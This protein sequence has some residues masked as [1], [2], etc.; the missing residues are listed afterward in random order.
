MDE[1][2]YL[3]S[4]KIYFLTNWFRL[5]GEEGNSDLVAESHIEKLTS[6]MINT[7][8]KYGYQ[9]LITAMIYPAKNDTRGDNAKPIE[10]AVVLWLTNKNELIIIDPQIFYEESSIVL[11]SSNHDLGNLDNDSSL[12]TRS[13]KD[14]IKQNIDINDEERMLYVLED[15]HMESENVDADLS[16]LRTNQKLIQ[17][18]SNIRRYEKEVDQKIITPGNLRGTVPDLSESTPHLRGSLTEF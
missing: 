1:I 8:V 16:S 12:I 4:K 14:Y 13:I 17:M 7:R 9:D 5:R 3:L 10:H 11:Y 15:A 6:F 2:S 18:I